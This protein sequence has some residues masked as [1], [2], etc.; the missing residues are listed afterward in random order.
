MVTHRTPFNLCRRE[1]AP[2]PISRP[3][4]DL[5][6]DQP[7]ALEMWWINDVRDHLIPPPIPSEA[8]FPAPEPFFAPEVEA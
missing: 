4:L 6:R 5:R 8:D 1:Q 7:K 2:R 3:R